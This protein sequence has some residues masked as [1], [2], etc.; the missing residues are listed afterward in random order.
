MR[1]TPAVVFVMVGG[2]LFARS[3]AAHPE[4]A[5]Q[6]EP[7]WS[8]ALSLEELLQIELATPSKQLQKAREAPGVATVVTREQIRQFG[9]LSLNDILFGQ[10]GFFPARDYERTVVGSRGINEGWNNNHLL[11]LVDGVPVNDNDTAGAYTWDITPL[12]MVQ[13]VEIVRGPGSALYGSSAMQGIVAINTISSPKTLDEAE[14]LQINS[15]A[16]LRLGNRGTAN[17]EAVA[18]TRSAHVST[19]IGFRF[20][21]T[22]GDS[23]FS[24]DGSGRTDE[25]GALQRFLIREP[26]GSQYVFVKLEPLKVLEGLSLSYHLQSWEQ[27]TSQ[28][29]ASWAPDVDEPLRERRHLAILRYHSSPGSELQQE[30]TLQF[31]RHDYDLHIRFYPSG[32][33]DGYYPAGVTE[34]LDT[35]MD[36]I[37]GRAQLSGPLSEHISLLGGVEYARFLYFG[38]DAHYSN[39]DLLNAAEGAP[40]SDTLVQLGSVYEGILDEPV[41]NAAAYVQLAWS[42]LLDMPL[43]LTAGLRYDLKFFRYHDPDAPQSRPS[44]RSYEQLSPRLALV[45]APRSFLSLKL[46]ASRAFRAPAPT[47]LFTTNSWMADTDIDTLRP[48]RVN[49]FEFSVDW[50]PDRHLNSRSTVFLS[51]YENLIGYELGELGNLFSRDTAGLELELM[52]DADLG[53]RGRLMAFGSYSYVHL[54]AETDS[55][56]RRRVSG[57]SLTWAPAHMVKAGVSY[58]WVRFTLALQGRYQSTV[59]RRETDRV[60]PAFADVRP[61]SVP[62]WVSFDVNARLQLSDWST[63]GLTVTNLL[64]AESYLARTGDFPFDY[65]MEGR[66]I[67]GNLE[68]SL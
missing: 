52:A 24:Y 63:V 38:D 57:G 26:L 37:F 29:W 43:S 6:E 65:R 30:Y 16:H 21:H 51:R 8:Q 5:P 60:T 58:S 9:W 25:T 62:A 11:V 55:D 3:A 54:L 27:G 18:A 50:T 20:A 13:S 56:T 39:A 49:T 68:I 48:E 31:Q 47:E 23:W 7:H 42:Q 28:G 1:S 40:P 46:Q 59:L 19:V 17:V 33:L 36:E 22:D 67:L 34:S 61:E 53:A 64:G 35:H 41:N 15:E 4:P 10:P 12:F 32:A 14:R 45:Y 2:A 44:A 66:R